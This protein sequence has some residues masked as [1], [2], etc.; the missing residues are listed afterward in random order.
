MQIGGVTPQTSS[1]SKTTSV[2]YYDPRDTNQD[3]VVSSAEAYAYSLTHPEWDSGSSS[4]STS[5]S[6]KSTGN[7]QETSTATVDF[8]A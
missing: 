1:S 6:Q 5:S 3:G 7:D 8:Y 2:T 4:N